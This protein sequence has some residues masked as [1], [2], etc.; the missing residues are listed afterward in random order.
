LSEIALALRSELYKPEE[1][2]QFAKLVDSRNNISH[3]F[4]PDIPGGQESIELCS[5]CLARTTRVK[6]A[7]GVI[8][9]LEHDSKILTRRLAT[10]QWISNNRFVLGIGTGF[11]G[12]NPSKTIDMMFSLLTEIKKGFPP[13]YGEQGLAFPEIMV[14][15]LRSGIAIK[16]IGKSDG[17]I[18]N[19]CSAEYADGLLS[20]VKKAGG[21][22]KSVCYIKVFYSGKDE[23]AKKLLAEEFVKYDSFPQYHRMFEKN[24]VTHAIASLRDGL[25]R[26]SVNVP[27]TLRTISIANPT[28]KE[29]QA[30]TDHFRKV[31][32]TIPCVYP[33]FSPSEDWDFKM[34]TMKDIIAEF[35]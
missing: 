28:T 7:S 27:E 10:I 20:K 14:A 2:L 33:Y 29:L 11:P 1:I 21:N 13:R 22:L 3:I 23:L 8:R 26:G 6:M 31:G 24:G 15:S 18:L 5:S 32:V 4:F 25:T 16:S 12:P 34:K 9:L 30:L 35:A 19:F 17:L